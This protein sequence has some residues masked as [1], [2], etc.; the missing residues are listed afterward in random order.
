MRLLSII[1][2]GLFAAGAAI[3]QGAPSQSAGAA[4]AAAPKLEF[5]VASI[6]PSQSSG[7]ERVDAGLRMDGAQAHIGS[8]SLKN[9]IAMAYRVQWNMVTGPDWMASARFDISAKLP[10]G[11]TTDQV[12][13]MLQSLLADR[14]GLKVHH[15]TK[16]AP[17]YAL[18]MGKP[19]LK[20]TE[21]P[22]DAATPAPNGSVNVSASGSAAGVSIDLGHGSSYTFANDQFQFHRFTMDQFV[23][24]LALYMDHPVV[25]MTGLTGTYDFTLDV[26][27]EDYYILLVR[28]G[29]NA[30]VTMPPQALQ[31]LGGTPVSLFDALSQQ[32]LRL[33]ARK[34]PLD[35]IVVDHAQQTPTE[36]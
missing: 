31:L 11:A 20:L 6:R 28:S 8:Q 32:G 22:A 23:R 3:G 24:Q 33:E 5:E 16:D 35:M 18:L 12:P 14:F 9:L 7:A 2:V 17:A 34:L 19:P 4:Q 36:N 10:D 27:Q 25:N 30:G 21:S 13:E 29:A 1:A 26:T 15:E